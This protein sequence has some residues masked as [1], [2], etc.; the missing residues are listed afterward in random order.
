MSELKKFKKEWKEWWNQ[1]ERIVGYMINHPQSIIKDY[2][3]YGVLLK[4]LAGNFLLTEMLQ[5]ENPELRRKIEEGMFSPSKVI[6]DVIFDVESFEKR[7]EKIEE[8]RKQ[9]HQKLYPPGLKDM[10]REE[11]RKYMDEHWDEISKIMEQIK[12]YGTRKKECGGIIA[13]CPYEQKEE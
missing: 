12:S 13:L 9:L 7:K 11:M 6:V 1:Y 2:P 4:E 10:S 3:R 5:Q 8:A